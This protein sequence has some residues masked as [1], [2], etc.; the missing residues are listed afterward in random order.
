MNVEWSL[1][2]VASGGGKNPKRRILEMFTPLILLTFMNESFF[3]CRNMAYVPKWLGMSFPSWGW[4]NSWLLELLPTARQLSPREKSHPPTTLCWWHTEVV[5]AHWWNHMVML[6]VFG[7]KSMVWGWFYY[8]FA[9]KPQCHHMMSLLVTSSTLWCSALVSENP[10]S[11]TTSTIFGPGNLRND[12][13][14]T[15]IHNM[16]WWSTLTMVSKPNSVP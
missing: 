12:M 2:F 7:R 15:F 16:K 14:S 11:C 9:P 8:S 10:S 1:F 5:S 6:W 3:S 13:R 4:E